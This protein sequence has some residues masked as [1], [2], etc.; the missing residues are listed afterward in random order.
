MV[1]RAISPERFRRTLGRG[2]ALLD[3]ATAGLKSGDVLSGDTAFKLYDTYGF[4]ADL[5]ADAVAAT[6]THLGKFWEHD[7]RVDLAQ[8]IRAGTVTVDDVVA[9]A[10]ERL[11][12][13]A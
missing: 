4:P 5:T 2:M 12:V 11:A 8:A 13:R 1:S 6:A 3:E 9:Q 10:I 7:M